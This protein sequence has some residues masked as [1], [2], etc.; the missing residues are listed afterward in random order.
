ML[1]SSELKEWLHRDISRKDK[2]LLVLACCSTPSQVADIKNL[3][4]ENGLRS[5]K[6]WNIS[7]YLSDSS[8]KAV[9]TSSGW[10][11]TESGKAHLRDLGVSGVSTAALQAALDLRAHL[12]K[13]S[14]PQTRDFVEE[15]IQCH[16][17]G[18][19]RSSIVMS[20]LGAMDTLHKHVYKYH[21][22]AF[23]SEAFR[24]SGNKWKKAKNTD[25]LGRMK[26]SDFLDRIEN[27]SIIGKNSKARLKTAL[28][29][30]NGCGHPNSLQVSTNESAAHMEALLMNVFERFA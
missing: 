30:R 26:E 2:L 3:A 6:K 24:V 14:D 9:R 5:A 25:D 28:D 20:W 22:S 29:L 1:T 15:A 4:A 12:S 16:E 13:I 19:Y 8:G 10:E 17:A 23:N 18:L 21:L 27:L 11:L 7:Q